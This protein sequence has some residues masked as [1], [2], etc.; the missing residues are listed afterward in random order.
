MI[1]SIKKLLNYK[2]RGY[3]NKTIFLFNR[4]IYSL[5][6]LAINKNQYNKEINQIICKKQLRSLFLDQVLLIGKMKV[7]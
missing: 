3:N 5:Q 7:V 1:L 4:I 6:F 2:I